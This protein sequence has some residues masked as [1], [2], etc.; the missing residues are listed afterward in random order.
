MSYCRFRNTL[1]DLRDCADHFDD[2][3]LSPEEEAARQAMYN[4]C[5][6]IVAANDNLDEELEEEE[7]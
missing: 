1:N 2:E 4:L 5:K 3:K 7:E 6:D